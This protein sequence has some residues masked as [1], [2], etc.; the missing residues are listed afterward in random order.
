MIDK[1]SLNKIINSNN[2]I[3]ASYKISK[4]KNI[5]MSF[6]VRILAYNKYIKYTD[7]F[8]NKYIEKISYKNNK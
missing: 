3:E 5:P 7:N 2:I 4:E 6:I 8:Y 1:T